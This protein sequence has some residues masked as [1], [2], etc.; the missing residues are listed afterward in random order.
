MAFPRWRLFRKMPVTIRAAVLGGFLAI[1]AAVIAVFLAFLLDLYKQAPTPT[2]RLSMEQV[3]QVIENHWGYS[4]IEIGQQDVAWLDLARKGQETEFYA[5]YVNDAE[6]GGVPVVDVFTV[7]HGAPENLFHRIGYGFSEGLRASHIELCGKTF[8]LC[9]TRAG[10][11]GY[12]SVWIYQYDGIGKLALVYEDDEGLF[13]GWLF[14]TPA[15]I[16]LRGNNQR[17]LLSY[18]GTKFVR[19]L[20][21]KPLSTPKGPGTHILRLKAQGEKLLIYYDDTLLSFFRS[22]ANRYILASTLKIEKDEQILFDDDF[23][24]PHQTR[25]LA[26]RQFEWTTGFYSGVKPSRE[27]EMGVSISHDYEDWYEINFSVGPGLR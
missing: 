3:K 4:G 14:L 20:Y 17:F 18:D 13:Q 11:A 23:D 1:A 2:S 10:N 12:L 26:D 6:S 27:G 16:F 24:M 19:T 7:Q 22:E 25:I 15:G 21:R 8:F 9:T 5:Y